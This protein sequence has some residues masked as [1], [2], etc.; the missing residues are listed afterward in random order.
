MVVAGRILR[1]F[2]SLRHMQAACRISSTPSLRLCAAPTP[3]MAQLSSEQ[4]NQIELFLDTLLDWNTRM[5]L[6]GERSGRRRRCP[7]NPHFLTLFSFFTS[8]ATKDRDEA[9][10]RH[11]EDS[12]ALLPALDACAAAAG[13]RPGGL[14]LIDVGSGAGLPGIILAIAR[15]TWRI[16]LLDSLK[17]RCNFNEAAAAAAGVPNVSIEWARAE[18][19]GQDPL[20]REA[21]D[22][23]VA[24]AVAELRV[25]AELCLPLVAVGGHWVAA[26]GAKPQEE[27]AAAENA[28]K[29]LGGKL[30]GVEE[31]DSEAPDGRRCVVVV[32]K[33]RPTK[34]KYPRRPGTPKKQP[35]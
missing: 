31:V 13:P 28:I 33:E 9:Y 23:A 16:T 27:V 8:A 11:V 26:K 12:L 4:R 6:T 29:E 21:H 15:P 17:K 1:P 19:A 22:V 30:V 24:R 10:L 25:L 34:N 35:L 2:V 14:S 32:K 3:Q 5:N 20:L 7:F 18:D